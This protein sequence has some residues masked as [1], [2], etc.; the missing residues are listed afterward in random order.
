MRL[1][2][3]ML[4]KTN[5]S[6][7]Y[8]IVSIIRGCTCPLYMDDINRE[9]APEQPP[10]I[11]LTCCAPDNPRDRY[12]LNWYDEETLLSLTQSYCGH[13]TELDYDIIIILDNDRPVQ[14]SLF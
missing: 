4:I 2:P 5:Y 7:P 10:H 13:K 1:E 12:W 8:R 11:H 14:G 9:G 6:G 3:G